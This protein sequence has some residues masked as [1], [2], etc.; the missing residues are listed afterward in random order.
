MTSSSN[1]GSPFAAMVALARRI[2]IPRS[3]RAVIGMMQI[4]H[5]IAMKTESESRGDKRTSGFMRA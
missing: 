2:F 5:S 4:I 1:Y 3:K